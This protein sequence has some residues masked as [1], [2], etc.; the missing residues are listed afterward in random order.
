[1]VHN[2][3]APLWA[4]DWGAD[5][6]L[7]LL[8]ALEMF[9][10]GN[11]SD[12]AD[13]VGSKNK[14]QC[15]TH[16][17]QVYCSNA[18]LLPDPAK[19]LTRRSQHTKQEGDSADAEGGV[20]IEGGKDAKNAAASA[21]GSSS[22]AVAL[23]ASS[24]SG[25]PIAKAHAVTKPKPKSGLGHLVG[26]TPNRG[27]F[28]TEYENDAELVLADMEFKDEDTK[29]ERD[30][31]L[32]VLE[33]YNSRLDARMERKKFILERN[34]L[35][36]KEKKRAK[37]EREIN[38]NMRVFAKFH[39]AEQHEAF[40]QG[41]ANEQRLRKRIEQLQNYRLNGIRS[42][43]DG[44]LFEAEK[45][46][47]DAMLGNKKSGAF[48]APGSG[49]GGKTTGK[50]R[51]AAEVAEEDRLNKAR[52][53]TG[54]KGPS[55]TASAAAAA[56][57]SAASGSA[58]VPDWDPSKFPGIELLSSHEKQL[59]VTL[60]MLPQHY[61]MIKERLI[62]EVTTL[63]TT[64]ALGTDTAWEHPVAY[65]FDCFRLRFLLC[66]LLPV[67]HSWFPQGE[68]SQ[69]AHQNRRQQ[70]LKDFRF[71]R[72]GWVAQHAGSHSCEC[73]TTGGADGYECRSSSGQQR[74]T[75]SGVEQQRSS[76]ER[77]S[78]RQESWSSRASL[79]R[80]HFRRTAAVCT[81]IRIIARPSS[82]SHCPAHCCHFAFAVRKSLRFF[83]T[84]LLRACRDLRPSH[85][86]AA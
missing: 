69:A 82:P 50:K 9:G 2:V 64:N 16:Y 10:M 24:T 42:L 40:V 61:L 75:S 66:F 31:K 8:E 39:S 68:S 57:S 17:D 37:E 49:V 80:T 52:K 44:E 26:F 35:E 19:A 48:D 78:I 60:Q 28:D 5:E 55:L 4:E 47:R 43:A 3:K 6:E 59:C 65:S 36:R 67:F 23:P 20:K 21:V 30:L 25:K 73:Q 83:Q 1:M 32:K 81:T 84:S 74:G 45:R 34:L 11:W 33:I 18:Q 51:S 27:D 15:E 29:W 71:L 46:K 58:P 53:D 72:F 63:T 22:S 62:R 13:H 79:Q 85:A 14:T 86:A 54:G 70:N 7:L 77:T 56:G 12:V 41:L 38:N 76:H